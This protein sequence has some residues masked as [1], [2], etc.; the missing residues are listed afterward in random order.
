MDVPLIGVD[1]RRASLSWTC[2]SLMDVPLSH[3]RVSHGRVSH[4][5]A[6]HRRTSLI[7]V[8]LVGVHIVAD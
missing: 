1:H 5:R 3:G 6:S 4:R 2:L 8:P 7:G